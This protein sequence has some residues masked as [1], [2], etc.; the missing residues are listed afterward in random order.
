[1]PWAARR[2]GLGTPSVHRLVCCGRR[3]GCISTCTDLPSQKLH[4]SQ[5]YVPPSQ[6]STQRCRLCGLAVLPGSSPCLPGCTGCAEHA[7][8]AAPRA[9]RLVAVGVVDV[10]PRCLSS[11]YLFWDPGQHLPP[12][13]PL[14]SCFSCSMITIPLWAAWCMRELGRATCCCVCDLKPLAEGCSLPLPGTPAP[15]RRPGTTV[16]GQADLPARD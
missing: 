16:A 6:Q 4:S 13:A 12:L 14:F 9:G 5:A 10:L 7:A 1:M 15:V 3:T 11:K 8:C 2:K